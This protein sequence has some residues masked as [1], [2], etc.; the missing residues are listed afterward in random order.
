MAYFGQ[1]N[2]LIS[3]LVDDWKI[4]KFIYLLLCK[5]KRYHRLSN[6]DAMH[7]GPRKLKDKQTRRLLAFTQDELVYVLY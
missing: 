1:K 3:W 7:N 4:L 6:F 5:I 2:I